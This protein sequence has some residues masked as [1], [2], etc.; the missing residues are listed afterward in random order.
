MP[1]F[2]EKNKYGI[3]DLLLI[4]Q[5]LR[6]PDGC[7][8]DKKQ[9]HKSIRKNFIEETYEVVEAIDT[10]NTSLLKEELGDV[11]LQIVFHS[12]M[13]SEKGSFGFSDVCDGICK[14]LVLRHPHIFGDVTAN[15]SEEVLENWDKIKNTEKHYDSVTDTLNGVSHALPALMRSEKVQHRAAKSGFDY[16][17]ISQ[18]MHDLKSE[19][20]ELEEAV[21]LKDKDSVCEELGDVL[22]SAVNVARFTNTH[23]E[24]ALVRSCDKFILRFKKVEQYAKEQGVDMQTSDINMLNS[25]WQEAKNNKDS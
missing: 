22:F 2:K 19:V 4:M 3:E 14:K 12:Q 10:D 17:D 18:A 9:D 6:A 21:S 5:M 1:D 11:L 13:E 15:T 20:A 16:R 7:P 8:W 25:L 24:E 23:P